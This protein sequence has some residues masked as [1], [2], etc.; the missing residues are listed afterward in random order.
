MDNKTIA[1]KHQLQPIPSSWLRGFY[2][3]YQ[4]ELLR[5]FGNKRWVSK[6]VF[7]IGMSALPAIVLTSSGGKELSIVRG[8]TLLTSF[9]WLGT[10]PMLIG[11]IVL[12]QGTIIEEKLT[13]TL[14]WVCSKPLSRPAFIFGKFAAHAVFIGLI[15]L[16]I[17]AVVTYV[18]ALMIGLPPITFLFGYLI[19]LLMIYSLL[20]FILALTLMLGTFFNNI[21]M[22][23]ASVIS[24]YIGGASLNAN[25]YLRQFELYSFATLQRHAVETV[26]GR[27][28]VAGWIAMGVT[29]LLTVVFLLVASWQMERHEL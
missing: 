27:L 13:Q 25:Q 11:T 7:W 29:F 22:V 17:P 26:A 8:T 3:I 21:G 4:K 1:T 16:G 20:L 19:S 14:L 28:S 5:W 9:L 15:M 23:T 18:A 10:A 24:A 2:P 6:L 12:T